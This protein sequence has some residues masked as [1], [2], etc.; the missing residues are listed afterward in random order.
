MALFTLKVKIETN[1]LDRILYSS[2]G[3]V[4]LTGFCYNGAN[5]YGYIRCKEGGADAVKNMAN[6]E[7][8]LNLRV[9]QTQASLFLKSM[10]EWGGYDRERHWIWM[11]NFF[12]SIEDDVIQIQSRSMSDPSLSDIDFEYKMAWV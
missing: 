2:F 5:L 6:K 1:Q 10:S 11:M 7:G 9:V 8:F 4:C 3:P 12:K